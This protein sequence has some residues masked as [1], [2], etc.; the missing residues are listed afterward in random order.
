MEPLL[1]EMMIPKNE[2]RSTDRLNF[3]KNVKI[4]YMSKKYQNKITEL[5]YAYSNNI[6]NIYLES[7]NAS[8]MDQITEKNIKHIIKS[9]KQDLAEGVIDISIVSLVAHELWNISLNVLDLQ[10]PKLINFLYDASELAYREKKHLKMI[11]NKESQE[12]LFPS[13]L[14]SFVDT[15]TDNLSVESVS[16]DL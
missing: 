16:I 13:M 9:L 10:N 8:S 3:N 7:T 6:F 15:D 5:N 14:R 2:R 1:T 12:D 4:T 11:I